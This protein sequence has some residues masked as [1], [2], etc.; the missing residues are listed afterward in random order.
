MIQING[1]DD[2]FYDLNDLN[3]T[4]LNE[5][6]NRTAESPFLLWLGQ[7]IAHPSF[8]KLFVTLAQIICL[9]FTIIGNVLVIISIFTYNPLRNVQNMFLVSLAVSDI[10]VA[11]C[12]LPLNVA[13]Y[14]IGEFG[15]E[16]NFD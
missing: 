7:Y 8:E 15:L 11:V 16:K 1:S 3:D 9:I 13:Y 10:T 2:K 12:I 14:L 4:Y 5:L 6:N